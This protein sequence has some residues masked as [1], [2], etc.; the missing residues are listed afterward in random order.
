MCFWYRQ[1]F[2]CLYNDTLCLS[3]IFPPIFYILV[4][5]KVNNLYF[6]YGQ[7]LTFAEFLCFWYA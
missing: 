6:W 7:K 4:C 1:K 3:P 5:L 2:I